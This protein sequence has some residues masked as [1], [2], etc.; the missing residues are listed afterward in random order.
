MVQ[1]RWVRDIDSYERTVVRP[2]ISFDWTERIEL[3]VGYDGHH[4]ENPLS[5]LENRAWQRIAYHHDFGGPALFT[6]FWL[7][8]RF[9]ENTDSVAWRGR[10]QIGGLLDLPH[11]YQIV[12]RNEFFVD[13]NE[14]TRIRHRGLG[15]NH[16]F[17][18]VRRPIRSWLGMEIGYLMQ[19][20]DRRSRDVFNHTLIIGFSFTTPQ[21]MEE[22]RP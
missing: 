12:V 10:F 15:E 19:Y 6:H 11:D 16:I 9:F 4:F 21:L 3:A 20:L 14:T 5:T 2:W 22:R 1:N 7:E 17:A 13:F 18:G 8:E